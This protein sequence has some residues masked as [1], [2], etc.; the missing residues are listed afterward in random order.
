[1]ASARPRLS[2]IGI[3]LAL[4]LG[5]LVGLGAFTLDY[6]EATSYLSDDPKA[7]VN[8]H[9]MREEYDGWQKA[10]HH[11]AATCN[12]CHVPVGF[13][14]R[15][16]TKAEHGWRHSKGFTLDDFPEPIRIT[17]S[18]LD[19]VHE[20]CVRCHGALV[21]DIHKAYARGAEAASCVH[22]HGHVGHGPTR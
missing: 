20:N 9:I 16:L 13:V 17:E 1:M 21:G 11:A 5:A 4:A 14:R 12:D 6:A 2:V 18:S 15:Y 8:C 19:V 22:C 7:C 10:S 3:V